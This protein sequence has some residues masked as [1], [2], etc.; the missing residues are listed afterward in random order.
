[1]TYFIVINIKMI[2][3]ILLILLAVSCD[4]SQ[5]QPL[6]LKKVERLP[7]IQRH[8]SFVLTNDEVD[9]SI[10]ISTYIICMTKMFSLYLIKNYLKK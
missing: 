2:R 10:L 9:K 4:S 5:M 3:Y 1:M 8:N 6:K 7:T